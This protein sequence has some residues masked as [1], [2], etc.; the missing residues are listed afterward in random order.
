MTTR[1]LLLSAHPELPSQCLHVDDGGHILERTWLKLGDPATPAFAMAATRT[2]LVVP[3]ADAR[4]LWLDL[5]AHSPAQALAAARLLLADHLA[6]AD[7]ALHLAIAPRLGTAS[8]L[9]VVVERSV[10]QDWLAHAAALG[11]TADAVVPEHLLLPAADDDTIR[12]VDA[13]DRWIVRGQALAFS[14]EPALAE[15]ILAGRERVAVTTAEL[16]RLFAAATTAAPQIDLLQ[17]DFAPAANRQA[18][19]APYRRALWLALAL[20]MSPL[21]LTAA[22]ALRYELA[23]RGLE[24]RADE[25]AR[26]L[27]PAGDAAASADDLR[28]RLRAALA[29]EAFAGATQAL[30]SAVGRTRGAH[31]HALDYR[32]EDAVRATLIH[33]TPEELETIRAALAGSGWRLVEGGS[34]AGDGN[35]RTELMLEPGA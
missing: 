13:G 35:L 32:R 29:P 10:M 28:A 25:V 33:A 8:R 20:L 21:L 7:D 15:Q 34:V 1:L 18:V 2:V 23:A 11:M 19:I 3:G 26:A 30:F 14:A 27:L 6:R 16:E 12:V 4:A 22:Q 31:L 5:P 9:V 24:A 17:Y